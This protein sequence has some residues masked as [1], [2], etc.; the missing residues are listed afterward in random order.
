MILLLGIVAVA[1]M[2]GLMVFV[3]EDDL[4]RQRHRVPTWPPPDKRTEA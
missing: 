3:I 2:G 1:A 4:R